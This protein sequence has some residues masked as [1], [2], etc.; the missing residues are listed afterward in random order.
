MATTNKKCE[1]VQKTG[2]DEYLLLHPETTA[3][4]VLLSVD[5]VTATNVQDGVAELHTEITGIVDSGIVTGVKGN[6]ETTY[7][8]GQVNVTK[9]NIGLGNVENLKPADMPV[10]TAQKTAIDAKA[11]KTYVDTELAKKAD[12]TAM[13]EK[14]ALKA[15]K[16]YVDTELGKKQDA[17]DYATK[18]EVDTEIKT[19]INAVVGE[20]VDTAFDTL[21][22]IADWIKTDE[23]KA[24]ELTNRV[25]QVETDI[26]SI[27]AKNTSQDTAISKAQKAAD[28]AATAA[29]TAQTTANKGVTDAA[30]AKS[31]ADTA[32]TS[33]ATAQSAATKAQG[34]AD[35]NA[36]N[37]T[38]IVNG[39]TKVA[40]A[41]KADTATS[42]AS[43]VKL[44]TARTIAIKGDATGSATFDG[45]ANKDINIT[46]ANTGVTAGTYSAVTVDAK[47]RVTAGGQ[48][49]E[50]GT[51]GQT[52]PS[53]NLAVGGLFFKLV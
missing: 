5:G 36:S 2:A 21:K 6:A 27:K 31:V 47:G 3:E 34:T 1:I 44:A 33:A 11:N 42:A 19:A 24:A 23:T 40:S 45:S 16:S 35:T 9:D 7:R 14:L 18:T 17:G 52:A 51:T 48:L 22:E 43:A 38:K 49:I 41:A 8:T 12:Q 37:I 46:L 53:T 50:I 32:T 30:A 13:T 20:N 29:S 28:D 10:S 15:D 26:T 25:G 39:T 4:N